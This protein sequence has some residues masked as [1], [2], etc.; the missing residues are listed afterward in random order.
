MKFND[1][2]WLLRPGVTAQHAVEALDVTVTSDT[3]SI[4]ALTRRVEHRVFAHLDAVALEKL[5]ESVG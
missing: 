3:V 1:G 4:A 2:Y 5:V